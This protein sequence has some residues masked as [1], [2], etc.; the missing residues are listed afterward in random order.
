MCTVTTKS[1]AV[2]V[3]E[4]CI[5][6]AEGK[7]VEQTKWWRHT[8]LKTKRLRINTSLLHHTVFST[9]ILCPFADTYAIRC[10]AVLFIQCLIRK[11]FFHLTF[12]LKWRNEF[13]FTDIPLSWQCRMHQEEEVENLCLPFSL[14]I[15]KKQTTDTIM[16]SAEKRNGFLS[17]AFKSFSTLPTPFHQRDVIFHLLLFFLF[18]FF[19]NR[20]FPWLEVLMD[21]H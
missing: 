19:D 18:L 13:H 8:R 9:L 10:D 11:N 14:S 1:H 12:F 5:A 20:V 17:M 15:D 4:K 3:S 2:Y 16:L 7:Y 21:F 6:F